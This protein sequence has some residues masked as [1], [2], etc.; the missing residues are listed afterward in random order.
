MNFSAISTASVPFNA[1][2]TRERF[3]GAIDNSRSANGSI[4]S[5]GSAWLSSFP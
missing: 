4:S 5:D 2:S 3:R 1:M